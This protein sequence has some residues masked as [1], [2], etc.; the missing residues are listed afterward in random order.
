MNNEVLV[1]K[2]NSKSGKDIIISNADIKNNNQSVNISLEAKDGTIVAE[3]IG[4]DE[5]EN[6]IKYLGQLIG[7]KVIVTNINPNEIKDI[8]FTL[9]NPKK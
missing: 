6:I 5:V 2:A 3:S 4:Y 1:F 9:A 8:S 7:K